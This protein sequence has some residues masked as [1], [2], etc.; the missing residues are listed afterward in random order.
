MSVNLISWL[1]THAAVDREI[2]TSEG[3]GFVYV[4]RIDGVDF[5]DITDRDLTN[6]AAYKVGRTMNPENRKRQWHRQ[7]PSQKHTWYA[8]VPVEHCHH[9]GESPQLFVFAER[10]TYPSVEHLVH[11]ALEEIAVLRPRKPCSD[12]GQVHHEIFLMLDLP[13]TV[14]SVIVPLIEKQK[15][16]ARMVVGK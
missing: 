7:C 12:C 14:E 13:K 2:S 16:I 10:V 9:V 1:K 6:T 3:E 4:F 5:S 8:P 11:V 15:P